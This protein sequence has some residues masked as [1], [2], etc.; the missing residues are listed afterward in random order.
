MDYRQLKQP[1]TFIYSVSTRYISDETAK[2]QTQ[3]SR[4]EIDKCGFYE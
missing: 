2:A 1:N 4:K 3:K